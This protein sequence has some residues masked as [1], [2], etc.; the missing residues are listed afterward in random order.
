MTTSHGPH[1]PQAQ[2]G[3]SDPDVAFRL[4]DRA[5]PRESAADSV[6]PGPVPR[7][8]GQEHDPAAHPAGTDPIAPDPHSTTPT[9]ELAQRIGSAL[10]ASGPPGWTDLTAVFALTTTAEA[11]E[12]RFS[13]GHG[14]TA[15]IDPPAQVMA[16]VRE[17][18]EL[19]SRTRPG[20]WWRLGVRMDSTGTLL[21]DED[22]GDRPFP[23]GQL[24]APEAYR[25]DLERH[26][27]ERLPVWLAAY[28]GHGDRQH[29]TAAQAV[30]R[31]NAD[32]T[33]GVRAA[34]SQWEFPDLDTLWARWAVLAAAFV[35]A[36]SEQGPRMLPSLAWFEG[37]GRSG[38]TLYRLPGG[39]AVLSG[40]VWNAPAL[41]AAYNEG[42]PMPEFY[43]GAPE[44]VANPVLNPR[45]GE[46][47]LSF[48]YW[49]QAGRWHRGESPGADELSDAVP[50]VWSIDTVIEVITGLLPDEPT[51]F[52]R[53]AVSDLVVAAEI[54]AVT[55]ERMTDVFP[56]EDAALDDAMYQLTLAG[57]VP[58]Q[59]DPMPAEAAVRQVREFV[60]ERGFDTTDYPLESLR[61]ERVPCG[62]MVYSPT[63]P[64]EISLGRAVFYVADDGVLEQSS[65]SISPLRYVEDFQRRF[66]ERQKAVL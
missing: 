54:R 8:V 18:R 14:R 32:R 17:H 57:V 46:G 55:R 7:P 65:S 36:G 43:S 4:G 16:L 39:R 48:C 12:V 66:D 60:T 28:I 61:A 25:A 34:V 45:V 23:A 37:A 21:A 10:E 58:A 40:G 30:A 2:P 42:A 35:A 63:R 49:W 13:D 11:A 9:D 53:H 1:R 44:W 27:R 6:R 26:P 22:Y 3:D 41:D 52:R 33:A 31:S 24:F 62:W 38:A 56:G 19:S 15:R 29:R 51:E 59:P 47:L 50:G 5:A 64:G 20:P